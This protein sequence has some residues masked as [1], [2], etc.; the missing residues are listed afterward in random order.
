LGA[1]TA[2]FSAAAV[3]S[4]GSAKLLELARLVAPAGDPRVVPFGP[5]MRMV[6]SRCVAQ[7]WPVNG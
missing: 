1:L 6:V 4:S 5:W 2:R 7:A 3:V